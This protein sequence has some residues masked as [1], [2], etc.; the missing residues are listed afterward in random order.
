MHDRNNSEIES[1]AYA[2]GKRCIA[3]PQPVDEGDVRCLIYVRDS[4]QNMRKRSEPPQRY[5]HLG[6]HK[7]TVQVRIHINA[8]WHAHHTRHAS[9]RGAV[10]AI[11]TGDIANHSEKA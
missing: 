2:I 5:G 6:A 4:Q 1:P 11:M 3:I 10:G 8:D 9:E 7:E